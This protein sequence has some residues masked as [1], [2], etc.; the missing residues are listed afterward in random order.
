MFIISFWYESSIFSEQFVL[1]VVVYVMA[2]T[3]YFSNTVVMIRIRNVNTKLDIQYI[4]I[5]QC[6]FVGV[7]SSMLWKV[8]IMLFILKY[9]DSLSRILIEERKRGGTNIAVQIGNVDSFPNPLSWMARRLRR[10]MLLVW[11]DY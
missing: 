8:Q 6:N 3:L 2:N 11:I 4:N 5:I 1:C 9:V 7:N 10:Q